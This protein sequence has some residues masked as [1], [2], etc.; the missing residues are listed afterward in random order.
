MKCR[1][2]TLGARL[3][4]AIAALAIAT[5]SPLPAETEPGNSWDEYRVLMERNIFLRDRRRPMLRRPSPRP[6]EPVVRDSDGD[7]VLIGVGRR[8]GEFVAFFENVATRVTTRVAAGQAVGK[9]RVQAITLDGVGY[10]RDG[11]VTRI[12][13]GHAL[14]GG[15]FARQTVSS[16]EPASTQPG[17]SPLP[18]TE[19]SGDTAAPQI[20][21]RPVPPRSGAGS[22]DIADILK[23]MRQR[24]EQE[25]R[26]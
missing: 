20:D 24:R 9:G 4:A 19:P 7:I 8:D 18:T 16:G 11:T 6:A 1:N 3:W 5:I 26:K 17:E 14:P 13:I 23:R 15:R 21:T 10:D 2:L 22:D 12:D 25:L